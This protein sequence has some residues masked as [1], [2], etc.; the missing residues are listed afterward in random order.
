ML[1]KCRALE[2]TLVTK[3]WPARVLSLSLA[4]SVSLSFSLRLFYE[5]ESLSH[6]SSHSVQWPCVRWPFLRPF[7]ESSDA[8]KVRGIVQAIIQDFCSFSQNISQGEFYNKRGK[9]WGKAPCRPC[10]VLLLV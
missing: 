9:K 1:C 2:W 8:E 4:L 6:S 5:D 7:D 10:T 3:V